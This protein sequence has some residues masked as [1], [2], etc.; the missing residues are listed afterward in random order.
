[1][2]TKKQAQIFFFGGTILSFAV[3]LGLTWHTLSQAVPLQ[4]NSQNLTD[5]VIYGKELWDKN[6]C[7]GCHTL[8]GEGAYYAPEL[9]KVY[10]RI[11]G[12][13]IESIL[14]SPVPWAPHGRQMVA[15]NMTDNEAKAMVEFFKWIGE[16][17]LNGFPAEPDL[18]IKSTN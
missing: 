11:G 7:M 17:D 13:M 14:K 9:T 15:Y 10:D 3:F 2:L 18:K 5:E 12:P 6:N 4:T 16:I 1:M 8:L